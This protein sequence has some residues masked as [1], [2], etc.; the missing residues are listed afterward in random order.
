MGIL[1]RLKIGLDFKLIIKIMAIGLFITYLF[2]L[3]S[4]DEIDNVF[5]I[6]L[7]DV[8]TEIDSETTWLFSR[9]MT[10]FIIML[11]WLTLIIL[12]WAIITPFKSN[13]WIRWIVGTTGVLVSI[14]NIIFFK[15]H[16]IAFY[17]E[18]SPVL[19]YR[20]VQ[21][22]IETLILLVLSSLILYKQIANKD[23]FSIKLI[24]IPI[25]ILITSSFAVMPQAIFYNF[26]GY[27]HDIAEGF[28][29]IHIVVIIIPIVLMFAIYFIMK[30]KQQEDKNL[31]LM[32]MAFAGV[33]QFFYV[34]RTGLAALPL[35]LC[36]AA[37]VLLFFSINFKIKS[38]F[39]FSY[40]ANV[41]G[42]L[43]AIL[44]PNYS[45]DVFSIG[46]IHFGFN[47]LYAF[48]V[49]ILG[50]ALGIFKRPILSH[51]YKALIVFTVYFIVIIVLNAWLN[52]Y[53]EVDYFF[54]FSDFLSNKL[55]LEKLQFNYV[56]VI[57]LFNLEFKF[58]WLFQLLFYLGFIFLM[59]SS[60]FVYDAIYQF[61]D[62]RSNLRQKEKEMKMD[63]LNLLE[64]LDGRSISEPMN[65]GGIDMIKITNFSKRYGK[66]ARFAVNNFSLE[67]PKGE[68]FG[69]LGHNGAG[70]STTIKSLVGIQS[71]TEGD[72]EICGYS[73]KTQPLEA[74]L[75]IG[76]VSDNHAVYEKLTGREYIYY[77]AN[78][79]GVSN[80]LRDERLADLADKLSITHALD[81]MAKSYSHG[82]KQKLVVIASL[83]HEPP[84]WILDEPL[85][86][87]DPISAYEIKEIM[88]NHAKK[89]NIVFFSSHVIE[90]VEKV[91]TKIA[92]ITQGELTG[93]YDVS[94]LKEGGLSLEELYMSGIK[95]KL[96]VSDV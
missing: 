68:I 50:V 31:L 22:G 38:L 6:F 49:P 26:F 72:M 42:A 43:A 3:F 69:F 62:N 64:L 1:K 17:G 71:I 12:T 57:N 13:T 29:P 28:T 59:F 88:K 40:F 66:S 37:V 70:K 41:L 87:L 56:L 8:K 4:F 81:Q 65:L 5:N 60:W 67:I 10:F 80:E 94:V 91:C 92:V 79:Y 90:V 35:H 24:W 19:S 54:T 58:F 44:I 93:V 25:I 61:I 63:Y 46:V 2:R 73:I 86:G 48:I 32:L 21:F 96:G 18:V 14:L 20:G 45:S 11:R 85:T 34:R 83:I 76:Y 53:E 82:M 7:I 52:N 77:I 84:V 55:G 9:S 36:N 51:M 74:K 39:Y 75:R 27:F 33:F 78:L 15:Q 47:H 23:Y 89:G 16:L 95:N 30:D